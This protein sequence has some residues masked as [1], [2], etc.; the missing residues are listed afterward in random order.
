MIKLLLLSFFIS[1]L[2]FCI[3]TAPKFNVETVA[4][5]KEHHDLVLYTHPRCPYCK[6][7][8]AYLDK[9]H[10][11]VVIKSTEESKNKEEL[12][13]IGGKTQVPCLVIDG[14]ALYESD[15]IIHWLKN[16]P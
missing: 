4:Y 5:K 11:K 9:E 10:R 8:E 15:A 12:K 6:K 16:N 14:N 1:N 2:A 3:D 7:V 13:R